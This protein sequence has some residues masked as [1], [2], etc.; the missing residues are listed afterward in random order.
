MKHSV[1]SRR[2]SKRYRRISFKKPSL[3]SLYRKLWAYFDFL[4]TNENSFKDPPE[5]A[6]VAVLEEDLSALLEECEEY[7]IP[8]LEPAVTDYASFQTRSETVI[9]EV[10]QMLS[11]RPSS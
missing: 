10:D 2:S 5:R 11:S 9:E 4:Q 6:C 1:K 3:R 7:L 8:G